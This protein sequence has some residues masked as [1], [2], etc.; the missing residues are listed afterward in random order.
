MNR[1]GKISIMLLIAL[2]PG[3]T[4]LAADVSSRTTAG[5][6]E[7]DGRTART[8]V[9]AVLLVELQ[10]DPI[11]SR[12]DVVVTWQRE[13]GVSPTPFRIAIPAGCF[14]ETR[15]GFRVMDTGCGVRITLNGTR[16]ATD[17]FAARLVPPEPIFPPEPVKLRI[18]LELAQTV[19]GAAEL[20][21]TLGGATVIVQIG[22]ERGVSP[23]SEIQSKSGISPQ[24]F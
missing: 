19:P 22:A 9:D 17:V 13:G 5:I 16:L 1:F 4:A 7:S 10:Q 14:V 2:L 21:A 12:D 20:L 18:R 23:A 24:P 3:A 15:N 8:Q 6:L 11:L